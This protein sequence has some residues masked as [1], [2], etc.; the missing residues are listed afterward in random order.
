MCMCMSEDSL[1]EFVFSFHHLVSEMW[2]QV[3]RLN[4]KHLDLLSHPASPFFVLSFGFLCLFLRWSFAL[5]LALNSR[6]PCFRLLR[7]G[8]TSVQHPRVQCRW[9]TYPF[10]CHQEPE[11]Q[12]RSHED[13]Q[14]QL[15]NQNPP[16][17]A[18]ESSGHHGFCAS[19]T[20][21]VAFTLQR[22]GLINAQVPCFMKISVGWKRH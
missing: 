10:P 13:T 1:K 21:Q 5:W 12:R 8:M 11:Q 16:C 20:S 14:A 7:A 2:T 15:A 19:V 3:F 6:S 4:S 18:C 17:R 9:L 22:C